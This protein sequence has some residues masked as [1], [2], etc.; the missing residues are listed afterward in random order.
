MVELEALRLIL[1]SKIGSEKKRLFEFFDLVCSLDK[2]R[3]VAELI[4]V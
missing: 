1:S 3:I 2:N 4:A